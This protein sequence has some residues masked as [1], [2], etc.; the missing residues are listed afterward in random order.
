MY[1]TCHVGRLRASLGPSPFKL[2]S[3]EERGWGRP[4]RDYDARRAVL[5][6]RR[7]VTMEI[8]NLETRGVTR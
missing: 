5:V 3:Q 4:R 7:L 8:R 1:V 6:A 2:S